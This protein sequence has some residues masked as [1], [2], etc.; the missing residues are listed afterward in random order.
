MVFN[1]LSEVL[2]Q[3]CH[4]LGLTPNN[5]TTLSKVLGC[6]GVAA[7]LLGYG[8]LAAMLYMAMY[9][10]DCVDGKLARRY[11]QCTVFG[12]LYDFDT[13][14]LLHLLLFGVMILS[15]GCH[16][17]YIWG[18][19]AMASLGNLYYG[20][21]LATQCYKKHRHDN[22]LTGFEETL[23]PIGSHWM[24]VMFLAI[25]KSTFVMYRSVFPKFEPVGAARA[26]K[27]L[28][29]VGP[30]TLVLLTALDLFFDVGNTW[31]KIPI[32][33]LLSYIDSISPSKMFVLSSVGG[34]FA[35]LRY[36]KTTY[37]APHPVHMGGL[38]MG[39]LQAA[40]AYNTGN[41]LSFALGVVL[42]AFHATYEF[43][44][45]TQ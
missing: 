11:D 36:A 32:G 22:F 17:L 8:E 42:L 20:L 38:A 28:R 9:V 30:G 44:L 27:V 5:V 4:A 35:Y 3:P 13:D 45:R 23:T 6:L 2:V 14:M 31:G 18:L 21:A 26:M 12:M 40:V 33:S 41:N 34:V 19:L 7:F 1:P 43:H 10:L 37:S 15:N 16:V 24:A 25:H 29:H 39:F